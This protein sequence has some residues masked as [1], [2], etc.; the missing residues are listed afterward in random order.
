MKAV[1][2]PHEKQEAT[3]LVDVGIR[4]NSKLEIEDGQAFFTAMK[5][6]STS[7][8]HEGVKFYLLLVI[9]I[10]NNGPTDPPK[11]ITSIVSPPIFVDSRKSARD[12]AR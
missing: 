5:F 7:Y 2:E 8:N 6:S 3:H 12:T 4:G 1:P 10:Q 9:F 11:I